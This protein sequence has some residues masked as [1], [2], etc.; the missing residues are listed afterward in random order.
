MYRKLAQIPT[1]HDTSGA[2]PATLRDFEATFYNLL[3]AILA[4]AGIT[5]FIMLIIGGFRYIT[6]GGDPK[7]TESAKNTITYAVAGLLVIAL[8][9]IIIRVVQQFIFEGTNI[10]LLDFRIWQGT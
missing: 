1:Y 7:S 4:L 3:T 6:S 2:S 10:N 8:A 9:Y 5:V